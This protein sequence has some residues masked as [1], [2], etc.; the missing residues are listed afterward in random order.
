MWIL[1]SAPIVGFVL[2][3]QLALGLHLSQDETP[4]LMAMIVAIVSLFFVSW[5]FLSHASRDWRKCARFMA[6]AFIFEGL[7]LYMTRNSGGQ[8]SLYFGIGTV[9]A[10]L[11]TLFG[12]LKH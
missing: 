11:L 7:V 3:L 8:G 9:V 12:S 6:C 10:G 5:M 1:L 2:Y 4:L